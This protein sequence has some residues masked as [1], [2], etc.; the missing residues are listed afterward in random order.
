M[1]RGWI[2]E[3]FL[4]VL[5]CYMSD[6]LYVTAR[7]GG[8]GNDESNRDFYKIL[9]IPRSS[10]EKEIKRAFKKMSLKHHPDKNPNDEEALKKF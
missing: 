10:T 1:K 4:M 2:L 5:V 9:E 8:Q 7:K 3:V 6:A